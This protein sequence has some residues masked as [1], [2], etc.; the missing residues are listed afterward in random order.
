MF[1][2]VPSQQATRLR[3]GCNAR[4]TT[5][6]A[7]S[8]PGCSCRCAAPS[9]LEGGSLPSL[10]PCSSGLS[11]QHDAAAG[12]KASPRLQLGGPT[13]S[14][15]GCAQ[16]SRAL[17]LKDRA[18]RRHTV[19]GQDSEM[20]KDGCRFPQVIFSGCPKSAHTQILGERKKQKSISPR[21]IFTHHKKLVC[22]Y[23]VG[24][25]EGFGLV[26]GLMECPLGGSCN[27]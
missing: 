26:W 4:P 20:G 11:P 10:A 1:K 8:L 23:A 12:A 7:Y 22:L 24:R 18:W 19:G 6:W 14:F 13:T 5:H 15:P 27:A 3:G 21:D 9:V 17:F 25:G 2:Q 16:L